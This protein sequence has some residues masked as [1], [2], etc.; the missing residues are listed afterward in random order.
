MIELRPAKDCA[1]ARR[2]AKSEWIRSDQLVGGVRASQRISRHRPFDIGVPRC[3]SQL[4]GALPVAERFAKRRVDGRVQKRAPVHLTRH[5]PRL[6]KTESRWPRHRRGLHRWRRSRYPLSRRHAK[7]L[8]R[9]HTAARRAASV[10]M[11]EEQTG[12]E[13]H[14]RRLRS[15][16]PTSHRSQC[17]KLRCPGHS[18]RREPERAPTSKSPVPSSASWPPIATICDMSG[19]SKSTPF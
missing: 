12:P 7:Q 6:G 9:S 18:R 5:R 11:A 13:L 2:P 17:A 15:G 16:A 8:A 4:C 14:P 10:R 3:P 19:V 1:E